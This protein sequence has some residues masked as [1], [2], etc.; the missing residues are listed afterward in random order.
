MQA[1]PQRDTTTELA[2]R[3][4]VH[5][6]GLRYRVDWPLPGL[7][8]RADMAFPSR[9]VAVFVDGCFWHGCRRHM[10]WPENN[11]EWWREKIEANRARDRDT[12]TKLR[13]AGWTVVRVWEH[14]SPSRA[15]DRIRRA[16]AVERRGARAVVDRSKR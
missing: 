14:E 10:T 16:A 15:A 12:N 8:R 1:T 3:T 11:A 7:R 6:L 2:V 4:A 13:S 9:L 5:A